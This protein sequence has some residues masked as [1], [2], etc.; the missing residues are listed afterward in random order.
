MGGYRNMLKKQMKFTMRFFCIFT[1]LVVAAGCS[2]DLESE[3]KQTEANHAEPQKGGEATVAYS[4]DISSLDPIKSSSGSDH[5]L[6][7]P[8]YDRLISFNAELEPQ[9][10]LAEAWDIPDDTTI[11][12][13]L[14]EGVKFHDGTPFDAEAVKFNMERFDSEDSVH[15]NGS[16]NSIENIEV[17]DPL[18]VK[19]HL[20]EPDATLLLALTEHGGMMVSPEAVK[21]YGDDYAQHPVGTGPYKLLKRVPNGELVFERFDDYWDEDNAHLDKLTIKIMTEENTRINALKSGEVDL[22]TRLNPVSIPSLEKDPDLIL[23]HHIAL[24]FNKIYLNS[25]ISPFDN[26]AVRLAVLHGINREEL[27]QSVNFGY[28]EPA[29]QPFPEGYW[30]TNEDLAFEYDPEKAKEILQEAGL[31]DVSFKLLTNNSAYQSSLA[32]AIQGQLDKVG[33]N[34]EIETLEL[35]VAV[36]KYYDEQTVPALLTSWVGL[37][38]PQLT[39]R[40]LYSDTSYYFVGETPSN[41][42]TLLAQ[43]NVTY[44][45]EERAQ[46]I[47]EMSKIAVNE[48]ALNIPLFFN[49]EVYAMNDRIKGVEQNLAGR[50][51]FS[52]LWVEE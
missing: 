12:L 38:E 48:E 19:L 44:D 25:L 39:M 22:A 26:K 50:I 36:S 52:K 4:V 29:Y 33:I 47:K 37:T 14:R 34:V 17:V 10:G 42:E 32:E 3:E 15:A 1:I 18:T 8:V 51:I 23:E 20:N 45:Q 46:L 7:Y 2:S 35:N 13:H 49:P 24:R 11:I 28:G 5:P 6:L 41:L 9:P 40:G 31:E 43:A 21:K 30:A 16:F 27:I